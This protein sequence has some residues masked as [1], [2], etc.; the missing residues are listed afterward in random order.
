MYRRVR[1]H[2]RLG[3]VYLATYSPAIHSASM[4][5]AVTNR[6]GIHLLNFR[7]SCR[8]LIFTTVQHLLLGTQQVFLDRQIGIVPAI[9]RSMQL[10]IAPVTANHRRSLLV[11]GHHH[12]NACIAEC[13]NHRLRGQLS[14]LR[15]VLQGLV[16]LPAQPF[17]ETHIRLQ[18]RFQLL[19]GSIPLILS[20]AFR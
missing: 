13:G 7:K 1:V 4:R 8:V 19:P 9:V 2:T 3:Q 18:P 11:R 14:C 20:R 15:V 16:F 10:H 12:V 17:L 6:I 5:L